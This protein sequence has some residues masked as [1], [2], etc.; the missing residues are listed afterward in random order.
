MSY[1]DK[2][3]E[4]SWNVAEELVECF[5]ELLDAKGVFIPC[6]DEIEEKDRYEGGN[7][8][9]LYGMEYYNLVGELQE[10]L[11][12]KYYNKQLLRRDYNER[13]SMGV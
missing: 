6:E 11:L 9:K 1:S 3:R 8:A 2:A 5:E 10:V 12:Q 4:R 13:K 7:E